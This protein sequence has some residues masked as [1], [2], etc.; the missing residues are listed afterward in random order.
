MSV[1]EILV[2]PS[3]EISF[4]CPVGRSSN[5][6]DKRFK[7]LQVERRGLRLWDSFE[8]NPTHLETYLR[9]PVASPLGWAPVIFEGWGRYTSSETLL[10]NQYQ[11]TLIQRINIALEASLPETAII[12][13]PGRF[14]SYGHEDSGRDIDK[15]HPLLLPGTKGCLEPYL[16]QAVQYCVDFNIRFGFVLTRHELVIFQ[17]MRVDSP[18]LDPIRTRSS[19]FNTSSPTE[20]LSSLP[21]E[22]DFSSP[23]RRET[24]DWVEFY[25][26]DA[27]FPLVVADT[28][29]QEQQHAA[30]PRT[31]EGLDSSPLSEFDNGDAQLPPTITNIH[32]RTQRLA[33]TPQIDLDFTS[34]LSGRYEVSS[35]SPLAKKNLT[36]DS[37]LERGEGSQPLLPQP[38]TPSPNP[39]AEQDSPGSSGPLLSSRQTA[40]TSSF[41]T[42]SSGNNP[43]QVLMRTYPVAGQDVALR[44]FQLI[45][46]AKRARDFG[47]LAIGPAKVSFSAL[48]SLV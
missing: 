14:E 2:V 5:K 19:R 20:I 43:T 13:D 15:S 21:D 23:M 44:L 28:N 38:Q 34:P 22:E 42:Y 7:T 17:L 4:L 31:S 10:L 27:E 32:T 30:A 48:D 18:R 16:A 39:H 25:N 3:G 8:E 6:G 24:T 11:Q 26:G 1:G 12:G 29:A 35:S 9:L 45:M 37:T 47:V 40:T 36:R 41:R 46:L 33:A